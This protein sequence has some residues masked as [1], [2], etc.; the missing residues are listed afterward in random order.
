[1]GPKTLF[2]FFKA[3]IFGLRELLDLGTIDLGPETVAMNL[4]TSPSIESC[5]PPTKKPAHKPP[6]PPKT[7]TNHSVQGSQ[8]DHKD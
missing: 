1:M 7:L 6:Q 5:E 2:L 8:N 3:P 4:E